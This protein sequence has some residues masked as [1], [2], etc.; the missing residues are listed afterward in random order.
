[1]TACPNSIAA[2]IL[3]ERWMLIAPEVRAVHAQRP[4]VLQGS[5]TVRI[6]HSVIA[7]LICWFARLPTAQECGSLRVVLEQPFNDI[8]ERWTR[9]FGSSRP[10]RSQLALRGTLFEERLGLNKLTFDLGV[11]GGAIVWQPRRASTLGIPWPKSWLAGIKAFESVRGEKYYFDVRL[12]LPRIGMIVHYLGVL[13][14]ER[15]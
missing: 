13:T 10:M 7:R 4:I 3:A 9:W 6:G 11:E 5:A 14:L 1:M 15:P 8:R 12:A 2:T